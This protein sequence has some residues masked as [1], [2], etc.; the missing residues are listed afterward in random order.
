M[1]TRF[2]SCVF[3]PLTCIPPEN[4]L[5]HPVVCV[6]LTNQGR[7]YVSYIYLQAFLINGIKKTLCSP[8][9]NVGSCTWTEAGCENQHK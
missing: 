9:S 7:I 8:E 1:S 4:L 3:W 6:Q 5:L 2:V